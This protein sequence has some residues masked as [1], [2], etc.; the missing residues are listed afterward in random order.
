MSGGAIYVMWDRQVRQYL[1]NRQR[2]LTSLMQPLL[3]LVAFGFGMG[4]MFE[5]AGN[6]SY[7]QYLI[8][9]IVGMTIL[10]SSTMNGMSLIWDKQFGFLKETLVAPV[11]RTSLLFGRCLGGASTSALQGV[12]VLVFGLMMGY[13]ITNL[14]LLPVAFFAMFLVALLFNLFGTGIASKFDDMH[15]FP[16]IMNFLVMPLFFLSGAL[17]PAENFPGPIRLFIEINPFTYCVDLL[18]YGMNGAGAYNPLVD[19]SIIGALIALLGAL[20]TYFFNRMET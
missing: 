7:L 12:I 20:G 10:M 17:F 16:T 14:A 11:S 13:Q 4:G 1:R 3:F 6:G 19:L 5:Q 9:G 8:P 2:L 18:K 15:S